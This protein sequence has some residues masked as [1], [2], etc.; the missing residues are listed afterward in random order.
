MHVLLNE[1]EI[2]PR[3]GDSVDSLLNWG[4]GFS[5]WGWYKQE[6]LLAAWLGDRQQKTV[7]AETSN[8][9]SKMMHSQ[10]ISVT[11][12]NHLNH[13]SSLGLADPQR[14]WSCWK[15]ANGLFYFSFLVNS[16]SK[17]LSPLFH[18]HFSRPWHFDNNSHFLLI[19]SLVIFL[20][21]TFRPF[22][23]LVCWFFYFVIFDFSGSP[24]SAALLLAVMFTIPGSIFRKSF[25][26]VTVYRNKEAWGILFHI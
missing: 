9:A 6:E 10:K 26:E 21:A 16:P 22:L 8:D 11:S 19:R 17:L 1:E 12:Q 7:C 24:R 3:L 18:C 15:A 14:S 5:R 2:Q 23:G 13:G 4:F 25:I 20:W